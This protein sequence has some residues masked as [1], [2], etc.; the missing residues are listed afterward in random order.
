MSLVETL[1]PDPDVLVGFSSQVFGII[2]HLDFIFYRTHLIFDMAV[3]TFC[4]L[5]KRKKCWGGGL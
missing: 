4:R 2:V 3:V 5:Q 1:P